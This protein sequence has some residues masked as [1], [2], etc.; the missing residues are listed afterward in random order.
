MD[1]SGQEKER[2]KVVGILKKC[3]ACKEHG[4]VPH[5]CNRSFDKGD[6]LARVKP[7]WAPI[8]TVEE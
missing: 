4:L 1:P 5:R 2:P 7:W 8:K 3:D 6:E